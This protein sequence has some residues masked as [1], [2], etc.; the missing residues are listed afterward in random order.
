MIAFIHSPFT[1]AYGNL[2]SPGAV[3]ALIVFALA[4]VLA[5][6]VYIRVH[7]GTRFVTHV[8]K[9]LARTPQALEEDA[10]KRRKKATDRLM[11]L[12][13]KV[14]KRAVVKEVYGGVYSYTIPIDT[15][16]A[17]LYIWAQV[18]AGIKGEQGLRLTRI[19]AIFMGIFP[20]NEGDTVL[21]LE[22]QVERG[23]II[24]TKPM[25]T[26]IL[27]ASSATSDIKDPVYQNMQLLKTMNPSKFQEEFTWPSLV[28]A[29]VARIREAALQVIDMR[30]IYTI[31]IFKCSKCGK[32]TPISELH[33]LRCRKCQ[34]SNQP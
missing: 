21:E 29:N 2:I 5:L 9:D 28:N 15:R 17:A 14:L 27:K 16:Q 25:A 13:M 22:A 33:G 3:S 30:E 1:L 24:Y 18:L 32:E 10:R 23:S 20:E 6:I 26:A 11:D 31:N 7:N 19:A 4:I 12:M 8:R 34:P